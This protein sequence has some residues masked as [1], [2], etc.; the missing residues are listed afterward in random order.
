MA[1]SF[2]PMAAKAQSFTRLVSFGDSLTD[3]GN[4]FAK[5]GVPM[6]PPYNMRFT[7]GLTFAEYLSGQ[8]APFG[9][10]GPGSVN[11]AFGGARTDSLSVTPNLGIPGIQDQVNTFL[12]SG[13]VFGPRDVVSLWGGAN[14]IFLANPP[15]DPAA[16][17]AVM[18][19]VAI[20]AASDIGKELQQIAAAGARTIL[21]YSLPNFGVLPQYTALGPAAVQLAQFSSTTFN[22]AWNTAVRSAAAA[23]P[24]TNIIQV[25]IGAAF[26]AVLANPAAFRLGNVTGQCVLTPSCVNSSFA[27]QNLFLFWDEV[28][29]TSTGQQLV[30]ALT[31]TYLY[32]PQ[33]TS[34]VPML[35]EVGFWS[36]RA[37]MVDGLDRIRAYAP[38]P[39]K[40]DFFVAAVGDHGERDANIVTQQFIGGPLSAQ[41]QQFYDYS[42]GGLRFGALHGFGNGFSGGLA[43]SALTG[44]AKAGLISASPTAL[45][46][47]LIG[48][49]RG[50]PW[51][52]NA[53]FGAAYDRYDSY[54]RKT[55]IAAL[56]EKGSA[57]GYSLN[58]ALEAGYDYRIGQMVF[59]PLARLS[60][61]RSNVQSFNESG[62][63]AMVAFGHQN[64]GA[65]AGGG[66]LRARFQFTDTAAVS[67]LVGYEN[68]LTH[69][70]GHLQGRLINNTA[71]PFSIAAPAPV[72]AGLQVGAGLEG[73]YNGWTFGAS[74]R[75]SFGTKNQM[76]HIAQL[77]VGTKW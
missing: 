63:A 48:G 6:S 65:L 24:G 8:M 31:R 66:E 35:S 14:N 53:T 43:L 59:T 70:A 19:G 2:V 77:T 60:Y 51:F 41:S 1:L 28:H 25:D 68:F 32:A 37:G 58:S 9:A 15:S 22:L 40:T 64:L 5:F 44:D 26:T 3:N 52:A 76:Q 49:W 10:L 13:G 39:D 4:L 69:S 73:A 27:N 45:G 18:A 33:M 11:Y 21:V 20:S 67:A 46:V 50:G 23:N 56:T 55:L 30:A 34:T 36:R 62:L 42:L 61:I 74:Y 57:Y 71:L 17:Q 7:N 75:G 54:E 16:A 72:G 38:T 12:G 47:D 29:P